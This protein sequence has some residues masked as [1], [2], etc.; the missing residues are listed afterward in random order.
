MVATAK[1]LAL[2]LALVHQSSAQ[3]YEYTRSFCPQA[4]SA[5]GSNP[6]NWTSYHGFDTLGYCNQTFLFEMA[7]YNPTDSVSLMACA[8]GDFTNSPEVRRAVLHPRQFLPANSTTNMTSPI[9]NSTTP[10]ACGAPGAAIDQRQAD[11]RITWS[12]EVTNSSLSSANSSLVSP[13]GNIV[14]ATQQLQAYVRDDA[15][16][17]RTLMFAQSGDTVVGVYVGS[18]VQKSSAA[19]VLQQFLDSAKSTPSADNSVIAEVCTPMQGVILSTQTIGVFAVTNG[20]VAA[21]Q[22][23]LVR[24]DSAE[25]LASGSQTSIPAAI[26]V[27]SGIQGGGVRSNDSPI[28]ETL[29]PLAARDG[30]IADATCSYLQVAANDSCWSLATQKCKITTDNFYKY[31]GGSDKLCNTIKSGDYV[32]CSAGSL[33][34][35]SPQPN[36]DG[37]CASYTVKANDGCK[38]IADAHQ[39]KDYTLLDQ[40]NKNTWGWAGCSGGLQLKQVICLSKG[41]P[42]MPAQFDTIVCGPQVPGTQK[43][44]NGTDWALL[45][46]C[47]LNA[48]C[49]TWGQCGKPLKLV[50]IFAANLLPFSFYLPSL[51][52]V[53]VY[54]SLTRV[55]Q[56]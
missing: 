56:V 14:V 36:A 31:N 23:A 10:L 1:A 54:M 37:T 45:N 11:L 28:N 55:T 49:D 53:F 7:I 16:C 51:P 29:L 32:C 42:N 44:T 20:D 2:G 27:L 34:D 9:A 47:P 26:G 19:A 41:N 24:W 33:P 40:Y 38:S 5:T 46:P 39:I 25:C 6:S 48:C 12:N 30:S 15:D 8:T 21:V 17:N 35:F 18:Q 52:K 3:G 43:P 22:Q 4:C 13:S 50:E